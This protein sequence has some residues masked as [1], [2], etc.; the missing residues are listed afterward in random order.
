MSIIG[1]LAVYFTIW[2][3]VLFAVLPIGVQS[4]Q[5]AGEVA[6]GTEPGAPVKPLLLK[7]ALWT[8]LISLVVYICVRFAVDLAGL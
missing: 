3:I 1:S 2:W 6:A 7:K 5:E 4:Q 8:T